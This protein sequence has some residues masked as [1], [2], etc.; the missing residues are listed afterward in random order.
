MKLHIHPGP[1]I[2]LVRPG[3]WAILIGFTPTLQEDSLWIG[4][5]PITRWLDKHNIR[6][7]LRTLWFL[8]RFCI[9]V[10]ASSGRKAK[11]DEVSRWKRMEKFGLWWNRTKSS[12]R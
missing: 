11:V 2:T 12:R 5:S 7:A 1:C 3:R 4:L 6:Q 8:R 9:T 10:T